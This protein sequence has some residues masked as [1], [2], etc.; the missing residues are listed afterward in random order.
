M[1]LF[2]LLLVMLNGPWV[3][4]SLL[5]LPTSRVDSHPHGQGLLAPVRPFLQ[6]TYFLSSLVE[7]WVKDLPLSLL[8]LGLLL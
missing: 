5:P 7:Q 8:W 6:N 2:R 3:K 1:H 4:S